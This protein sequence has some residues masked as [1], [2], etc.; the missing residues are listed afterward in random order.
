MYGD[1][2]KIR[3]TLLNLLSNAS[4]FTENG[5]I[6]LKVESET[7]NSQ[8]WV[9][10]RVIDTGIGM[11]EEQMARLF[12]PFA[13]ADASTSSKFGGTG[14]GLAIL[15]TRQTMGGDITIVSAPNAGSTFTLRVPA[16]VKPARSPYVM[17]EKEKEKEKEPAPVPKGRVLVIDDDESVHGV[18]TNMLTRE[19]YSTRIARNGKE[20]LRLARE[21]HPDIVILDILMPGMDGWSVLSS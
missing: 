10:M 2:T 3:Q 20:G 16:R 15:S 4:K 8:A 14:L 13:Q 12:K 11:D 9:V 19:G 5:R 21:Y 17:A 18:L 6:N 1:A 7:V